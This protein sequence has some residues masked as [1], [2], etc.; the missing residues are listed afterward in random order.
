MVIIGNAKSFTTKI[1]R[2]EQISGCGC[3][4]PTLLP[5]WPVRVNN[6]LASEAS[7]T[8][9]SLVYDSSDNLSQY[10]ACA[11]VTVNNDVSA[12]S[13]PTSP[14]T[15]ILITYLL[16]KLPHFGGFFCAVNKVSRLD[17]IGILVESLRVI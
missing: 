10:F 12:L 1:P 17:Q 6:I 14:T 7:E 9:C 11:Y 3:F 5:E 16:I 15:P 2:V 13:T 4:E 8:N